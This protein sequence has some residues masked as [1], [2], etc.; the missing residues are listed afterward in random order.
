MT[1]TSCHTRIHINTPHNS[2][3]PPPPQAPAPPPAGPAPLPLLG[4]RGIRPRVPQ[5]PRVIPGVGRHRLWCVVDYFIAYTYHT[6]RN[7]YTHTHY[8][9]LSLTHSHTQIKQTSA[10]APGV[11]D[12]GQPGAA[13]Q[14][15]AQLPDR[16]QAGALC[17]EYL[18][19]IY[20][21][22]HYFFNM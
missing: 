18:K 4:A 7:Y 22:V 12:A 14:T 16:V 8:L 9:S 19:K 3:P 11:A 17:S 15:H 21:Y 1:C 5:A 6:T 10:G 2:H 13:A 20:I